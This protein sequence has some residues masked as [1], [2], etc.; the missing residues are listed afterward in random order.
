LL[1]LLTESYFISASYYTQQYN[2]VNETSSFQPEDRGRMV[3]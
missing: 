1:H 2:Y 3:L